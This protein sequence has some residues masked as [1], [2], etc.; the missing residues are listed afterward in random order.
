VSAETGPGG[1]AAVL[2]GHGRGKPVCGLASARAR[3]PRP[4]TDGNGAVDDGDGDGGDDDGDDDDAA[5]EVLVSWAGDG[6]VCRWWPSVRGEFS[7][8]DDP[9]G[10]QVIVLHCWYRKRRIIAACY[11]H[12][13]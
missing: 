10:L 1:G 13:P 5:E 8:V 4:A 3:Y 6:C 11:I 9:D 7:Q 12:P 2:Y